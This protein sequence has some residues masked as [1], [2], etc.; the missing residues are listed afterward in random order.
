MA[1]LEISWPALVC[2]VTEGKIT[3]S[4]S[5]PSPESPVHPTNQN[6]PSGRPGNVS[7]RVPRQFRKEPTMKF[8][9]PEVSYIKAV[10]YSSIDDIMD[11]I[12]KSA[13]GNSKKRNLSPNIQQNKDAPSQSTNISWKI[14]KATQELSVKYYGNVEK[15]GSVIQA[16][17][18]DLKNILGM[19]TIIDCQNAEQRQKSNNTVDGKFQDDQ[20]NISELTVVKNFAH[21]P[22]DNNA[23]SHTMFL[24]CDLGFRMRHWATHKLR[25]CDPFPSTAFLQRTNTEER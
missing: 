21:W 17:S 23:G 22:V 10:C 11:A 2:N 15:H 14:D 20:Q 16:I 19:T 5:V 25:C 13:T 24:Y 8:S 7:M 6:F 3:V 9:T 4:K 1:L 12:M 18:Q